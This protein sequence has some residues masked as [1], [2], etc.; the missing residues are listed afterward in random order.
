MN[1]DGFHFLG[2]LIY[3]TFADFLLGNVLEAADV[4]GLTGRAYR[5]TNADAYVQDNYRVRPTLTLNLGLRYEFQ[6]AIGDALG[7]QSTMNLADVNPNPP[8]GGAVDGYVVASNFSGSLPN[9]VV[10]SGHTSALNNVGE[11]DWE[12]RL[13]F[14]WRLPRTQRLVLRAGYG[15]FYTRST[16]EP[17]L[18]LLAAPPFGLYR[19]FVYI[20][21][22]TPATAL[23]PAPSFP[24]FLPYS[25]TT[26]LSPI[27]FSPDYQPARS[28]DYGVNLQAEFATNWLFELGYHGAQATHLSL[29]KLFDQALDA[30]PSTPV[31]GLTENTAANLPQRQPYLGFAPNGALEVESTGSSSYNALEASLSKRLSRGLEFLA[32]YTWA[33][34]LENDPSYTTAARLGGQLIG[35]QNDP[36]ANYGFDPFIR[37]QRLIIS[38]L[39]NLP[40]PRA[41]SWRRRLLGGWQVAG[42]VTFQSGDWLTIT[43][44]DAN[45]AFLGAGA[46]DFPDL[47]AG[48]T[49]ASL[50][51]SG[52]VGSRLNQY[53]NASCLVAPP[54]ITTDGATAFGNLGTSIVRGPAE[55]DFDIAVIKNVPL[56]SEAR[57]LQFRGEFF[58]AFNTPSFNDPDTSVGTAEANASGS[59]MLAVSNTFGTITSTSVN[60]RIIQLAVK[61]FF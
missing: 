26:T 31:R 27:I 24:Q 38:Y 19:Q 59:P 44:T 25:P 39:Y 37:P 21:P 13:G 23:P 1:M 18:Q 61:L 10:R 48:C 4:P 11:N 47:A 20:P 29:G 58:N 22:A 45:N 28:Q 55:Q 8:A 6:G 52:S 2:A 36:N 32:S 12:P 57:S 9:G 7:R 34:S 14:A 49:H 41:D 33:T 40:G 53:F 46:I 30:S 15:L 35:N 56:W 51:T 16:G 54:V 42:V 60:P 5:A 17:Y 3:P 43:D 50:L